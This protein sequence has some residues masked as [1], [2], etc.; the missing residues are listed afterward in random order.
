MLTVQVI[1]PELVEVIDL[2]IRFNNFM[3]V[4]V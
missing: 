4:N 3:T 1:L 2:L